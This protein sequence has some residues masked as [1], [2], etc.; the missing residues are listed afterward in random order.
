MARFYSTSFSDHTPDEFTHVQYGTDWPVVYI[1]DDGKEAYVGE[2]LDASVRAS[3][4]LHN[5]ERQR[6]TRINLISDEDYNK[7]VILDLEAFLI[8]HMSADGHF[9]LQNGNAGLHLHN[10]YRRADY[11]Q[12]FDEIW[13]ELI[14]RKLAGKTLQEIENSDLFKYSPYNSLSADQYA[15]VTNILGDM[16]A[17]MLKGENMTA[18]VEGGPGTGKT[19]LAVYMMKLLAE[20]HMDLPEAEAEVDSESYD[21]YENLQKLPSG[22]RIGLVIPM[23]SLRKTIT[24]VFK[25]VGG[26]KNI[27]V[28]KP[29]EV[30]EIDGKYDLL[31][32]DEAHRL[33][34]RYALAHYPS[35][36]AGNKRL[37]LDE[38]GTEL[39]WIR[40]KSKYQIL[41]YDRNQTVR[42][43]DI[44]A[45]YFELLRDRE[46]T[47]VYRLRTQFRCM[48]GDEYIDYI[49]S[50]FSDNPPTE[51]KSFEGYDLRLFTDC[52]EMT[53]LIREMNDRY[54]LCRTVAGYSWEWASKNDPEKYDIELDGRSYRWNTRTTDWVNSKESINEVGCIHTIQGYDL[55][56]AAIII[57]KELDYDPAS[58]KLTV[59][60]NQ[61]LDTRGKAVGK[62]GETLLREQILNV[63]S[64]MLTR[65]IRG[66]FV[67]VCNPRLRDYLKQY[68]PVQE[69][70][71]YKVIPLHQTLKAAEE[72][73]EYDK[74]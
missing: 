46:T 52:G 14:Q 23:Q 73:M 10:Y 32:V 65:G 9:E 16:T 64:T 63:Y 24:E 8:K 33:Q 67:Y 28:L 40:L 41:F 48:A 71:G 72:G 47:K 56:Y 45:S 53:D 39:D 1:I 12:K 42:P 54:G 15:A 34:R 51:K 18:L 68:I 22:M 31:V 27:R 36:D 29:S 60:K 62:D 7:S 37:N 5:P 38:N 58:G 49:R 69:D 44:P 21:L 43:S 2:T 59:N 30:P 26:L 3:Q 19:V 6:L 25:T 74:T 57:G 13:A 4:H 50:I 17:A 35:F 70:D 66:T 61:Y 20:H 55:N 11:H